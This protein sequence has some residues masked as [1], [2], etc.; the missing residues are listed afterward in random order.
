MNIE[1]GPDGSLYVLD[2]GTGYFAGDANS[3]LYRIDYVQGTRT[4]VAELTTNDVRPRAADRRRSP[5]RARATRTATDVTYAWDFDGDGTTDSTELKPTHTYTAAGRYTATLAVTDEA[6]QVGR[7]SVNI[8]AGN[9]APTVTITVAGPGRDVRLRRR[10]PLHDHGH[11]PR[12]R[13]DRLQ[14]GPLRHRARPQRAHARRP[15]RSQGCSGTFRIAQ[16]WEDKTQHTFYVLN[17]TYTDTTTGLELTGSDQVVLERKQQQAEFLGRI[18]AASRSSTTRAPRAAAGSATSSPA[19][20][21]AS[22][23]ST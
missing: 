4:P 17:A 20:G 2:Y 5:P 8:T 1:F 23:T 11:R 16:P 22:T 12:G 21:S 6:G 13:D 18:R 14:Q 7:A 15:E 10:D 19:T 3:A 9:T